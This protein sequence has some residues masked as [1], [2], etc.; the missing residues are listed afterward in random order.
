[1]TELLFKALA[2]L[3]LAQIAIL[4]WGRHRLQKGTV[5]EFTRRFPGRCMIC[6]YHA[7]GVREG[8]CKPSAVEAHNCTEKGAM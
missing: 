4:L 6:S 8:F 1:M 2:F 3:A 7:Y 5:Q